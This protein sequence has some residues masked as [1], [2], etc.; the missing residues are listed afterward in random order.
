VSALADTATSIAEIVHLAERHGWRFVPCVGK[1]PRDLLGT[2]WPEKASSDPAVIASWAARWPDANW[3]LVPGDSLV[4]IDVDDPDA[5]HELERTLGPL[6]PTPSH[7]TGGLD[8]PGR[9]RLLLAHPGGPL[10][11]RLADG[12]ELIHGPRRQFLVPPSEHPVSGVRLAWDDDPDEVALA[13]PPGAW[14]A[15]MREAPATAP[16]T[17]EQLAAASERRRSDPLLGIPAARWI[18]TFGLAPNRRGFVRCP[19]HG[20]GQEAEPSLKLY[21]TGWACWGCPPRPWQRPGAR[22]LGG[23][24][25]VFAA[26]WWGLAYPLNAAG[27]H[28]LVLRLCDHLDRAFTR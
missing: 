7:L 27:W 24:L 18:G 6:P 2:G 5:F 25:Y 12:V 17:P 22:C 3:G 23:D 8:P 19:F 13:H 26:L 21:G 15:A 9:Y 20:N 1:N 16:R 11:A 4:G 10:R 28:V 14:L